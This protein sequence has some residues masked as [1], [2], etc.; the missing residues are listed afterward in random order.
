MKL[1]SYLDYEATLNG[2]SERGHEI[3]LDTV[4]EGERSGATRSQITLEE[5][6]IRINS[7]DPIEQ[8]KN[9]LE[10]NNKLKFGDDIEYIQMNINK[11]KFSPYVN[12]KSDRSNKLLDAIQLS[13]GR[14]MNT[15]QRRRLQK[16]SC[17]EQLYESNRYIKSQFGLTR[18]RQPSRESSSETLD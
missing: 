9:L 15:D 10:E 8:Y 18:T 12:L 2:K 13:M 16:K 1:D 5:D 17:A 4:R 7:D 11:S 6:D 3:D 14:S